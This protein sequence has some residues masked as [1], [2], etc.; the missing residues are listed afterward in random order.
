MGMASE[1]SSVFSKS[2]TTS[3]MSRSSIASKTSHVSKGSI[4]NKV[5]PKKV[6][7]KE[8]SKDCE[9]HSDIIKDLQETVLLM[10]TKMKKY[11]EMISIRDNQIQEMKI[12]M[13]EG[14]LL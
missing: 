9:Q 6:E 7:P 12:M 4:S 14:G 11:E 13:Q 5:K 10:E 2:S 3:K 8:E 1:T